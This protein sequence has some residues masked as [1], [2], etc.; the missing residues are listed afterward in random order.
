MKNFEARYHEWLDGNLPPA[1][2]AAFE[3]ELSA[4]PH[5]IDPAAERAAQAELGALL[6]R[7]VAEA[8]P[9]PHGDFFNSELQRRIAADQAAM[10]PAAREAEVLPAPGWLQSLIGRL[11]LTSAACVL[12]GVVGYRAFVQ[13]ELTDP[14]QRPETDYLASVLETKTA[15]P[16]VSATSFSLP[17]EK[18]TVLWL[19][20]TEHVEVEGFA[21]QDPGDEPSEPDAL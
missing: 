16:E 18:T 11:V 19:S 13:P 6:R 7:H 5:G 4:A 17:T 10:Q 8:P 1:E 9:M 20:G 21:N 3:R 2:A 14:V 15:T 12:L